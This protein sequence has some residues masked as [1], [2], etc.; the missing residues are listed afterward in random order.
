LIRCWRRIEDK[1]DGWLKR[2]FQDGLRWQSLRL[3]ADKFAENKEQI[4]SAAETTHSDRWLDNLPSRAWTDRY[5]DCW[6]GVECL[7]QASRAARERE[8]RKDLWIRWGLIAAS[9]IFLLL[10]AFAGW[11]WWQLRKAQSELKI[12]SSEFLAE[13]VQRQLDIIPS[14]QPGSAGTGSG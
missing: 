6:K 13:Q 14:E 9:V 12:V 1:E 2:E 4:L 3:Q 11:S 7:M 8:M 10:T 5:K